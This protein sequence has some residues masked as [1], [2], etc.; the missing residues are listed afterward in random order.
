MDWQTV[1]ATLERHIKAGG[2]VGVVTDIDGTVSP[3]VAQYDA[4]QV[5]PR[6]R[7]L[8]GA[9]SQ[10][11]ALVAAVSGRGV[12]DLRQ[13]VGVAGMVYVGNHG[14]ERWH[15]GAIH[16]PPEVAAYR[17]AIASALA[18]LTPHL[19]PGMAIEDKQ[20]TASVHYRQA[21]DHAAVEAQFTPAITRIVEA[22]GLRLFPG[23]MVYEIRPPVEVNKGTAFT[24][25]VQAYRLAAA[26]YI[27]DDTTDSDALSMARAL[28][29]RGVAECFGVGVVAD[30]TP[31]I[32]LASADVTVDGVS[33]V[34]SFLDWLLSACTA[35]ST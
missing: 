34:E 24:E 26:V 10:R 6:N 23:R 5:T 13:R 11:L 18:Q 28:R 25:L 15:E 9:L 33:G 4:A 17:P 22:Q 14:M 19:L 27:G 29:E 30:E 16:V 7:E 1:R 8:L 20:V 32:V 31:Q 12:D 2:R 3:I 21:A 35:S